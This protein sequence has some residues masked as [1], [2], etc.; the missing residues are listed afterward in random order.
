VTFQNSGLVIILEAKMSRL[1]I[2][3]R[4]DDSL[5][6]NYIGECTFFKVQLPF[7]T[8]KN[9][10]A[11]SGGGGDLTDPK[12]LGSAGAFGFFLVQRLAW[13][14]TASISRHV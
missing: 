2:W 3:R 5:M 6:I 8:G 1:S 10:S 4:N 9:R 11:S 14:R 13:I 7:Q 12:D